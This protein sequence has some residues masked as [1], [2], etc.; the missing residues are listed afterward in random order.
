MTMTTT[1]LCA[2]VGDG[3]ALPP[4]LPHVLLLLHFDLRAAACRNDNDDDDGVVV[5][6]WVAVVAVM[7]TVDLQ[8][9]KQSPANNKLLVLLD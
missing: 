6:R 5:V 2:C 9:E 7:M 1:N 8:I 3:A 4:A